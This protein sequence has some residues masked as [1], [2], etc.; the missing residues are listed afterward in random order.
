MLHY[1]IVISF[2]GSLHEKKNYNHYNICSAFLSLSTFDG[3][4]FAVECVKTLVNTERN[5]LSL[6]LFKK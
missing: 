4:P 6:K 3:R 2:D 5:Y 1:D